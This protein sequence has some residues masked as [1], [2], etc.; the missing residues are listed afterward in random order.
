MN[1]SYKTILDNYTEYLRTLGF[2]SHTVKGYP[3]MLRYFLLHLE[4]TQGVNQIA[5]LTPK[6]LT[7]YFDH[8]ETRPNLRS[9]GRALSKAHLNKNFDAVDKFLEFLHHVG[10]Q[11]APPPTGYRI[12]ETRQEITDKVRVL[13][14][15]QVATLYESCENLFPKMT[16]SEAQPR[17]AL[18]VVILDLCYACGLRRSEAYK[19]LI[20]DVDFD[21]K[22]LFIRQAKGNKDRFVPLSSTVA[23]RL[24]EFIYQYRKDFAAANNR[25]FPLSFHSLPYYFKT[26]LGCSG[27]GLDTGTGLHILRHSIATHLLQNGMSVEQIGKFL[28]H[29]SIESTQVYTHIIEEHE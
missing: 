5:G 2:S 18:A 24:Q 26:L 25:V 17:R 13:T 11:A 10:L 27:L 4:H 15:E 8:L 14:R 12:A 3:Q 21:K 7:V 16:F 29:S 23:T 20:E 6:H 19:L 9:R 22:L 28:G 1:N